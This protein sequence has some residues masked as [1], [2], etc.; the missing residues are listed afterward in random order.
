MASP[1]TGGRAG[2]GNAG[3]VRASRALGWPRVHADCRAGRARYARLD[4]DEPNRGSAWSRQL[5]DLPDPPIRD[6]PRWQGRD[7]ARRPTHVA[8]SRRHVRD[9]GHGLP[10]RLCLSRSGREADGVR[11]E[12]ERPAHARHDRRVGVIA[13]FPTSR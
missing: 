11:T 7:A 13:D 9:A 5:F 4:N 1:R 3:R 12:P 2:R 8:R 6:R 10:I